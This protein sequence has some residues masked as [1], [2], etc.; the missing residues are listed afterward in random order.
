MLAKWITYKGSAALTVRWL[1]F[2]LI[3][4][5]LNQILYQLMP[6]KY[7]LSV[8][9]HMTKW[10]MA[11]PHR[12]LLPPISHQPR[13]GDSCF[14]SRQNNRRFDG[15]TSRASSSWPRLERRDGRV[16]SFYDAVAN[17]HTNITIL[18][19][20]KNF[21]YLWIKSSISTST[22]GLEYAQLVYDP[23]GET[24]DVILVNLSW[25]Y[26]KHPKSILVPRWVQLIDQEPQYLQIG[27]L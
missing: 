2:P 26:C 13:A 22:W 19:F 7:G 3:L 23:A 20:S 16:A 6:L 14:A 27:Q 25:I 15:K 9:S 21:Q 18:I 5:E 24:H 1:V 8:Y 12:Q 10:R 17:M 4:I 11:W